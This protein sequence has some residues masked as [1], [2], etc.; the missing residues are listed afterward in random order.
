VVGIEIAAHFLIDKPGISFGRT[1]GFGKSR[2]QTDPG[3]YAVGIQA[4]ASYLHA[5]G[6][7][8]LAFL[9]A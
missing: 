8:V 7:L 6:W 9:C 1:I 4:N 2:L 5:S 3:L